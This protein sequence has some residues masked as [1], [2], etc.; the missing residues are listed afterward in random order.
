MH[1]L[2]SQF[3]QSTV[4]KLVQCSKRFF[5]QVGFTEFKYFSPSVGKE[6]K[7]WYVLGY[8]S[9]AQLERSTRGFWILYIILKFI[10]I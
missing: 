3:E 9:L 1:S 2:K 7:F 5:V 4:C 10:L 8:V 6:V